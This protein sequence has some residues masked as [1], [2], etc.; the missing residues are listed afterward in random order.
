MHQQ[1]SLKWFIFGEQ[2]TSVIAASFARYL[3]AANI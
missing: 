2:V 3:T 1:S